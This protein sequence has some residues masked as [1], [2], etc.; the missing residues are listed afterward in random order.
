MLSF[1]SL[2]RSCFF[3]FN[4]PATTEIYTLSLHDALPICPVLERPRLPAHDLRLVIPPAQRQR[5]AQPPVLGESGGVARRHDASLQP[6]RVA[7]DGREALEVFRLGGAEIAFR[8]GVHAHAPGHALGHPGREQLGADLVMSTYARSDGRPLCRVGDERLIDRVPAHVVQQA[9]E[10]QLLVGAAFAGELG[11]LERVLELG[12]GLAPVSGRRR[13]RQRVE[14]P[15][16]QRG[17]TRANFCSE[18][19]SRG[20]RWVLPRAVHETSA[21]YR[22]PRESTTQPCGAMNSPGFSPRKGPPIRP[23]RAPLSVTML[24]RAPRL[25]TWALTGKSGGSSPTKSRPPFRRSAKSPHGRKR[26]L[27]WARYC[28]LPSKTWTR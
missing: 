13:A 16:G 14:Q 27:S 18:R 6:E 5:V 8:V 1:S 26:L 20:G 28:P 3:F 7:R 24:T 21:T 12:H 4:D 9:R 11:A 23:T 10:L 25:G 19:I 17:H 22:S 15:V 2:P